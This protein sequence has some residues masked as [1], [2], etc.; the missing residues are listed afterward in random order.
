AVF[1]FHP[2]VWWLERR[3]IEESERACDEYVLQSGVTPRDYA[4]GI[5]EVCRLAKDPSPVFV[6]G[7]TGSDLRRRIESILQEKTG[8]PP[9]VTRA[10]ALAICAATG[11][12]GPVTLGAVQSTKPAQTAVGDRPRFEVASIKRT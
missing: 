11:I 7:I 1:W 3:L 2:L 12:L 4:E 5:L 6:A 8:R 9:G 10:A